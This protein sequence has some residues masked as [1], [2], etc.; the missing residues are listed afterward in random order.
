MGD[1]NPRTW[2]EIAARLGELDFDVLVPGH[3]EV[4]GRSDLDDFRAYLADVVAA[5]EEHGAG[6]PVPERY[7]DWAFEDG[8]ARN[9]A[10]L[11][12]RTRP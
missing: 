5:A 12:E 3:G 4:G 11:T 1:G 8:W 6:A 10:F 7:R 9:L 2:P